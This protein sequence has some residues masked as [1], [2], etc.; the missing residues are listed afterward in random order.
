M[1]HLSAALLTCCTD[2]YDGNA[3]RSLLHALREDLLDAATAYPEALSAVREVF[4]ANA[5]NSAGVRAICVE[6]M[7]DPVAAVPSSLCL[8]VSLSLSSA[9]VAL[10]QANL[11]TGVRDTTL[12][13]TSVPY[14]AINGHV[15]VARTVLTTVQR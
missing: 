3:P 12:M 6:Y 11:V 5:A 1:F 9:T 8:S 14:P 13:A 10:A 7:L 15:D 4:A 2:L